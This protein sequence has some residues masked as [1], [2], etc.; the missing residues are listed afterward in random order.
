MKIV[1]AGGGKVGT[2]LARQLAAEEDCDITLIDSDS[3]VLSS[4]IERYDVIGFCGNCAVK[5]VLVDAG[6]GETSL[7]IAVT[8]A[9]EVNLLSCMVAK[10]I[11]PNIP[12]AIPNTAVISMKCAICSGFPWSSIPSGRRR[13]RSAV[14]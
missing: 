9:D 5:S 1:I 4:A 2:A 3:K 14:F 11:N 7:L 12:S 8:G 13:W 6:I 10:N